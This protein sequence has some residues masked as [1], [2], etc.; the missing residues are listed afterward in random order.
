MLLARTDAKNFCQSGAGKML[1][2]K[3]LIGAAVWI[4]LLS[5]GA[6][7]QKQDIHGF[8]LGMTDTEFTE[9]LKGVGCKRKISSQLEACDFLGG[10]LYFQL[11]DK[12]G[13][14]LIVKDIDFKFVSRTGPE[15]V[16]EQVGEQFRGRHLK[17]NWSAEVAWIKNGR[18]SKFWPAEG[19]P[20]ADY[21]PFDCK[22]AEWNLG[23]RVMLSLSINRL[24]A[25]N[26]YT[27]K[28]RGGGVPL[29]E[30][31]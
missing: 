16:I 11:T 30:K 28:L 26:R 29:R 31:E 25:P 1:N 15:A 13:R 2:E 23:E 19:W 27:L 24:G 18:C 21:V 12:I 6:A 7:A 9:Q 3:R 5:G 8:F 17:Q 4:V 14:E 22:I 20:G 10:L